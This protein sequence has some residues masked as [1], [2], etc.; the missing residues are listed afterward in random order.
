[1][2]DHRSRL[3]LEYRT[4]LTGSLS[5]QTLSAE[6]ASVI[7]SQI[8]HTLASKPCY[9]QLGMAD[10]FQAYHEELLRSDRD[11]KTIA[12]YWQVARSYQR[13][14]GAEQPSAE[15]AK[16]F[17][18]WLRDNG[19]RAR[20]VILYYHALKVFHDFIGQPFRLKLRK[21]RTLPPYYDCGDVE[22]LISQ[23]RKGLRGQKEWQKKRNE[24]LIL[25]LAYTGMRKSELLNLL[26]GDVDF[27]RRVI[28][29]RK[30][31]GNKDRVVP[32]AER[33]AI[34]LRSQCEGKGSQQRVFEHLNARGVYRVIT[35]LARA[36]GLQGFHPHSLRHWFATQLVERGANLRDVQLLLGHESLETTAVYVD[37]SAC[38]LAE[39][40]AL[41]ELRQA[42]LVPPTRAAHND[43]R[44]AFPV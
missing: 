31:K 15:T 42:F 10:S 25:T 6:I 29:A 39:T 22:S 33:I 2:D 43:P 1:M 16:K 11:S 27:N 38:R 4:R 7:C 21:E 28:V 30:G 35:S 37:V 18:A 24:A 26:V 41:L 3:V 23:A 32:M 20:S 44:L 12:R 13:W 8:L 34:P 19:Y 5:P 9:S 17:I 36:C 14:L 40:V